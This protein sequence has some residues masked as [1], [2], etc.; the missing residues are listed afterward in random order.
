MKRILQVDKEILEDLERANYMAEATKALHL[1]ALERGV[2]VEQT[3]E[4]Y[5][6]A[7]VE[8]DRQKCRMTAL[9]DQPGLRRWDANFQMG[10]VEAVFEE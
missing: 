5:I 2:A 1:D 10:Y 6:R 8:L 4:E 3:R 7:F 9:V